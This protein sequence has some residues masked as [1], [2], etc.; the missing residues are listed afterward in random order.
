M[1]RRAGSLRAIGV[2]LEKPRVR[3]VRVAEPRS[4]EREEMRSAGEE[5]REQPTSGRPG[6]GPPMPGRGYRLSLSPRRSYEARGDSVAAQATGRSYRS[7]LL[8]TR[9]VFFA[10]VSRT[11]QLPTA[12]EDRPSAFATW[13]GPCGAASLF[14][15]R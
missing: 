8:L 15:L 1:L 9:F 2:D 5:R 4:I 12:P 6:W 3:W 13:L 11:R 14:F 10:S 7:G